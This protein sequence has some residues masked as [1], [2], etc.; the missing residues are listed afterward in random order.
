MLAYAGML[1]DAAQKAG[2]AT[3]LNPEK[4]IAN[5][6]PYFKVFKI[7]QLG[8]PMPYPTV[9]Y[10]NAKVVAAV[11]ESEIKTITIEKL[12][13]RGFKIDSNQV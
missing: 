4:F 11:P 13:K 3:P 6:Y 12:I 9:H 1:I 7:A 2:I 8:Q 5:E 10:D